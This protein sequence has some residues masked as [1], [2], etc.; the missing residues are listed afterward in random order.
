MR[1][2]D[3]SEA[4]ESVV[5]TNVDLAE[6]TQ[7]IER[8]EQETGHVRIRTTGQ[9]VSLVALNDITELQERETGEGLQAAV[10]AVVCATG[11]PKEDQANPVEAC[12]LAFDYAYATRH[13]EA[14]L[15]NVATGCEKYQDA[16]ACRRA[17]NLPLRMAAQGIQPDPVYASEVKRLA[18][19]VCLSGKQIRNAMGTDI[20]DRTCNHFASQFNLAAESDW[21]EVWSAASQRHVQ[22]IYDPRL[23]D[24]LFGA[25]CDRHRHPASCEMSARIRRGLQ[26]RPRVELGEVRTPEVAD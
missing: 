12:W 17:A 21:T 4:G 6:Y 5:A 10:A 23:A 14:A 19:F 11:V 1:D 26:T 9:R 16:T 7:A 25:A 15:R 3:D 13:F 24:R 2:Q 20:T 18:E 8:S 22:S